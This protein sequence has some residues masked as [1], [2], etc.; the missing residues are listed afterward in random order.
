MTYGVP[1]S[2]VPG[3]KAKADEV[4]ANF[5]DILDKIQTVNSRVDTTNETIQ[6]NAD[7]SKAALALKASTDLSNLSSTGK[8]VLNAKANKTD[9]DGNWTRKVLQCASGKAIA[10]GGVNTYSLKSYLP[11]DSRTYE[12]VASIMATTAATAN[13]YYYFCLRTDILTDNMPCLAA[14]TRT[15]AVDRAAGISTVPVGKGRSITVVNFSGS[16]NATYEL[17]LHGYRKVK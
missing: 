13:T 11:S 7:S 17:C 12:V 8:S 5:I 4:N 10:S 16:G 15:A 9:L 1:Y 6:A 3:T 2:F 14:I